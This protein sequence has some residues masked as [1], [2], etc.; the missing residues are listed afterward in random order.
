MAMQTM[1]DQNI[2]D[3]VADELRLAIHRGRLAPGTRLV[4]RKLA[5]ELGV[6]H[7]PIREALAR[8]ADEG[9]VERLPRRGSRVA[10]PSARDLE[11][12]SSVRVLLEQEVAVRVQARLTAKQ[13]DELRRIVTSMEKAAARG[14]ASR[15]FDLDMRF[16]DRLGQLSD[17]RLLIELVT[18][19]RSRI[20]GFLRVANG[21]LDPDTLAAHAATHGSLLDAIG[22]G[23]PGIARRAFAEHIEQAAARVRRLPTFTETEGER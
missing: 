22:S 16:H 7:I 21:A 4:E 3:R 1:I 10:A 19:L 12:I 23:D 11:E 15:L 8:L 6:S 14:D 9:L 2:S 17:H 20:N 18:Q 13:A 5:A